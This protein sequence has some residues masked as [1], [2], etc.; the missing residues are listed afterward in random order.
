MTAIPI[1]EH[2]HEHEHN[3]RTTTV[4]LW[5]KALL[6]I[7]L[8]I[9]FVYNIASGNIFNYVNVRFAWLSYVAAAL[10]LL[11]GAFSIWHLLRDHDHDEADHAHGD[12]VH[13]PISW[14]VLVLLAV[15][16]ALGTLIPSQPLGAGAVSGSVSLSSSQVSVGSANVQSL[17]VPP[18]QRNVL[19]WLRAFNSA[20][21]QQFDGQP[22]DVIGFVYTEPSFDKNEFMV[23]RFSIT[24]CVAD[25][26]AL[27]LPVYWDK[28]IP[29]QGQW[30]EVKGTFAQG[31]FKGS[32]TPV[33]QADTINPVAQPEHPYLY[34]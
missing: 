3:E 12:H 29:A 17:N 14:G 27:G 31:T 19:D 6:L 32:Q 25:A 15:P 1:H 21:T 18:L 13:A 10:F 30:I 9:Y 34:P 33:L 2:N 8:G 7:G 22:A 20:D 24:C 11:I 23:A 4:Q 16:L 28:A 5:V 26:T